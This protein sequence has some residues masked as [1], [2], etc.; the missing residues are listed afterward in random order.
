[1]TDLGALL[2]VG[3]RGYYRAW[4]ATNRFL[5]PID[6][7]AGDTLAIKIIVAFGV[8]QQIVLIAIDVL[9]CIS[10]A[11]A[12]PKNIDVVD[13]PKD[14]ELFAGIQYLP[15]CYVWLEITD[16]IRHQKTVG[17]RLPLSIRIRVWGWQ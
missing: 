17:E 4:L 13:V 2:V 14:P 1:M 12:A 15:G 11:L 9:S 8:V 7:F 5:I 16:F 6:T 3:D 10:T